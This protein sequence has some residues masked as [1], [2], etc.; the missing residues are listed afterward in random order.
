MLVRELGPRFSLHGTNGSWIKYGIDPQEAAL[1]A[2]QAPNSPNW[3]QEPAT[4]W[5]MINTELNGLALRGTVET[6]AGKY[7]AYYCNLSQAI[8]VKSDIIVQANQARSVIRLIELAEQSA[9]EQ[10]TMT[11]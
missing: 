8:Q 3:G 1:K 10:R 2:G 9:A 4:D 5:G 11:I 7:P 6:I